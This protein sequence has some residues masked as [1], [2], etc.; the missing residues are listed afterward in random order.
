MKPGDKF[1]AYRKRNGEQIPK[2]RFN[3]DGVTLTC[4]E[5]KDGVITCKE[6]TGSLKGIA[7]PY[8][9]FRKFF[10]VEVTN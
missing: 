10:F 6:V 2:T 1:K 8:Q 5:E 4:D 7:Q 9:I 3:P